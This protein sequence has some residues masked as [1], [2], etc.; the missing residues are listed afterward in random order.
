METQNQEQAQNWSEDHDELDEPDIR[1]ICQCQFCHCSVRTSFG[2][3]DMC[4][5]GA[6][7]G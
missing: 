7:Q 5:Q 6:H 3:C 2:I 1:E 4:S